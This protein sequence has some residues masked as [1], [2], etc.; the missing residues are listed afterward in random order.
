MTYLSSHNFFFFANISHTFLVYFLYFEIADFFFSFENKNGRELPFLNLILNQRKLLEY[1]G[2]E[3]FDFHEE[4]CTLDIVHTE[5]VSES[6]VFSEGGSRL[7]DS[8]QSI[9]S[10][11]YL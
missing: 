4:F 11:I 3:E 1:E 9:R 2:I 5:K 10:I 6:K 7:F 8:H